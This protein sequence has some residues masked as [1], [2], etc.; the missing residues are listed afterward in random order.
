MTDTTIL[1]EDVR[2]RLDEI[3]EA[4]VLIGIPSYNNSRTIGHVVQAVTA[5]LAKYFPDQRSVLVNSDGGSKDGTPDVVSRSELGTTRSILL[6]HRV[7]RVHKVIT[8]YQ[9]LPGKG[10]AFRTVFE[11]AQRLG[12]RAC[13]VV[14]SDL[15]S[16]TPEWIELLLGPVLH[17][18]FDYVCPLYSRHKYDGT[19]TN[20]IVYPLVRTLYGKRIRQPIGGDFGFSGRLAAPYLT[21]NV[22]DSDVARYGIDIW[23]TTT[24]LMGDF[25]ICQSYLGAKLHDAKDPGADLSAMLVQVTGSLFRQMETHAARWREIASSEA[26]PEFGFKYEVGL[27]PIPVNVARMAHTFTQGVQDFKPLYSAFLTPQTR[28]ELEALGA[29]EPEKFHMPEDLWVRVVYEFAAAYHHPRLNPDHLLKSLTPLYLGRTTSWIN[30]AADYG[31]LD[32]ENA[33][34]ALSERF[35]ALKPYLLERWQEGRMHS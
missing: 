33:L 16:I 26:V 7:R 17:E 22:W 32:V 11:I 9:G 20:S 13:A 34:N 2:R 24:A 27:E 28:A 14:D 10:S 29:G 8:A 3:G 1:R 21:H 12:A 25:R 15:R 18:Q 6:S 31:A 23:M 19:I 30:Q 35:E 4:D 5:G